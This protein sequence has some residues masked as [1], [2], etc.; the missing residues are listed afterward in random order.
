MDYV[1]YLTSQNYTYGE[2]KVLG[3]AIKAEV[4]KV[5]MLKVIK[6]SKE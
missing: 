2:V 1:E 5:K 3:K 6:R 4:E